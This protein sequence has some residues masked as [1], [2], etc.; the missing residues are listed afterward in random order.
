MPVATIALGVT[1]VLVS[2]AD[3]ST[4]TSTDPIGVAFGV[5]A[6]AI[7]GAVEGCLGVAGYWLGY[8]FAPTRR[9]LVSSLAATGSS[10]FGVVAVAVLFAVG[11]SPYTAEYLLGGLAY[12]VP[13]ALIA[14]IGNLGGSDDA[15]DAPAAAA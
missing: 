14:V 10:L 11:R 1:M 6:G 15:P 7:W 5:V 13:V 3:T 12:V 8:T 9:R 4:G 2:T